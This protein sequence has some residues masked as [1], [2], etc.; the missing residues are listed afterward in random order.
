MKTNT[1]IRVSLFAKKTFALSCTRQSRLDLLL[2]SACR[3]PAGFIYHIYKHVQFYIENVCPYRCSQNSHISE[4]IWFP[5]DEAIFLVIWDSETQR[6]LASVLKTTDMSKEHSLRP[7]IST[8][9]HS[10]DDMLKIIFIHQ[11]Y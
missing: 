10:T 8:I 1:Y 3:L 4:Q 9:W 2:P 11:C 6:H 7:R 5:P